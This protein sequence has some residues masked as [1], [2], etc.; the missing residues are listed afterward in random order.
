MRFNFDA[1]KLKKRAY[2]HKG[3]YREIG[4][5]FQTKTY[6]YYRPLPRTRKAFTAKSER[7]ISG[8]GVYFLSFL[9]YNLFFNLFTTPFSAIGHV[10]TFG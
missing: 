7:S 6:L 8:E 3:F 9:F 4:V 2:K 5:F 10:Y 1:I